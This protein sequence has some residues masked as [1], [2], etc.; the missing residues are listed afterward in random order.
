M[1][2]DFVQR[3]IGFALKMMDFI[4]VE[5]MDLAVK[6]IGFVI[7]VNVSVVKIKELAN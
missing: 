1:S 5:I 7:K 4:S 3:F 2:A 6:K